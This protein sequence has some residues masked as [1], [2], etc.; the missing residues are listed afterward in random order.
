MTELRRM[1]QLLH[2]WLLALGAGIGFGSGFGLYALLKTRG[3]RHPFLV[4]MFG[5]LA[6]CMLVLSPLYA[7]LIA[8]YGSPNFGP[9]EANQSVVVL[10]VSFVFGFFG[11]SAASQKFK[12]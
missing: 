7:Y 8:N 12:G 4:T 6:L 5:V 3:A 1:D 11:C 9:D 10:Y 2:D